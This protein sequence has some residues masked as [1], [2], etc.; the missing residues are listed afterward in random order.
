MSS[1][2]PVSNTAFNKL[3]PSRLRKLMWLSF[4]ALSLPTAV[5]VYKSYDQLKWEAFYQHRVLAEELSKT[6]DDKFLDLIRTEQRRA[7]SDYAFATSDS[8]NAS[9]V[10][11]S[12]LST[13]PIENANLG[14]IGY[15]QIDASGQL[16]TP[17]LPTPSANNTQ[18]VLAPSDKAQRE[19]IQQQIRD[20]LST[21]QLVEQQ[22]NVALNTELEEQETFSELESAS[23]GSFGDDGINSPTFASQKVSPTNQAA[24]DRLSESKSPTSK[25]QVAAKEKNNVLNRLEELE[26]SSPY[27]E[28]VNLRKLKTISKSDSA[29]I[30]AAVVGKESKLEE[31]LIAPLQ[32]QTNN[33]ISLFN[34]TD[35]F[36]VSLLSSGHFVLYRKVWRNEQRYIQGVL[37]HQQTILRDIIKSSFDNSLLFSMSNLTVIYQGNALANFNEQGLRDY[38]L[39][40][41]A[42]A[43]QGTLLL[44]ARLSAP[45]NELEPVFTIRRLPAS[46]GG[47]VIVWSAVIMILMLVLVIYSLYR[48]S[49]RNLALVNQQQD[50]VSAVSHELKTP[51]T[52]I[53]MYGEIL[54]Q[55][56]ADEEKKK[57]YYRFI[58][59]ESERL[60][61][62]INNVLELARMT[63][64]ETP[65]SLSPVT[66]NEVV[67]MV[68]SKIDSQIE[69]AQFTLNITIDE[70]SKEK[71]LNI[72]QDLFAQLIIN[73][74][75]NALKFSKNAERKEINVNVSQ[76]SNGKLCF[77][78]R[79]YG[80]GIAKDQ[81][82]KIFTLFYRTENELTR[83]TT[84]TGIGLALVNQLTQL[85]NGKIDVINRDPGAEFQLFFDAIAD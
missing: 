12:P 18:Y 83:N 43:L 29:N 61:R 19:E 75:D 80:P 27:K 35:P 84:G 7:F 9:L 49:L 40:R 69:R 30:S 82:K 16:S 3:N 21:N 47:K 45:F 72:D 28:K 2:T 8:N 52:S 20:I 63:R 4:F 54:Q 85:M 33:D 62:L 17:F 68:R 23:N 6:I 31:V 38:S 1:V 11:R 48:M 36:E 58:F 46:A 22:S 50:F 70:S 73:L 77:S 13:L 60:T 53:R 5:L 34:D 42:S 64:N 66:V 76:H 32:T 67:D 59:D 24:F 65:V 25:K 26:T 71:Q 10:K 57:S 41:S 44:R 78:I 37:L 14:V 79:D 15:F 39:S 55:G 51:L 56:W 81:L 74:V